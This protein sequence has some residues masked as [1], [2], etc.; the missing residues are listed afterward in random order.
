MNT[1]LGTVVGSI[2]KGTGRMDFED[3]KRIGM[4]SEVRNYPKN[5]CG[6]PGDRL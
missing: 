5:A 2:I 6:T 3:V 1:S 4:Q